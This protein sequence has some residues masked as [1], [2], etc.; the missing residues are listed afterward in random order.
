MHGGDGGLAGVVERK[1]AGGDFRTELPRLPAV[2]HDT[3]RFAAGDVQIDG[4]E[5]QGV[6]PGGRP[7]HVLEEFPGIGR[8]VGLE[9][10]VA[11]L[12]QPG[13]DV[14]GARV[15]AKPVVG[16]D[17]KGRVVPGRI[18]GRAHRRVHARHVILDDRPQALGRVRVVERVRRVVEAPEAVLDAVRG[19]E[20]DREQPFLEAPQFVGEHGFPLPGHVVA[21]RQEGLVRDRAVGEALG[22]LGHAEGAVRA[23]QSLGQFG[24]IA[25][26]G[27][28]GQIG[29]FGIDLDGTAVEGKRF[30]TLQE[31]ARDARHDAAVAA[32]EAQAQ[33]GRPAVGGD[34]ARR[35][36]AGIFE[37]PVAARQREA[38]Y[39]RGALA[40]DQGDGAFHGKD[41]TAVGEADCL[42]LAAPPACALGPFLIADVVA[43]AAFHIRRAEPGEHVRAGKGRRIG[44]GPAYGRN[45]HA[46]A[47]GD[48]EKGGRVIGRR[49]RLQ[50]TGRAGPRQGEPGQVGTRVAHDEVIDA[51][52]PGV[53]SGCEAGPGH[54]ALGGV[55]GVQRR[56]E[57]GRGQPAQMGQPALGHHFP[58][59]ARVQAV[60]AEHDGLAQGFMRSHGIRG[61]SGLGVSD[62]VLVVT[63]A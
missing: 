9:R 34:A 28:D 52:P 16:A 54:G 42:D 35:F 53:G 56:E 30:E 58:A 38:A 6:G 7:V 33:I 10:Q 50:G 4:A 1:Q 26:R 13:V 20:D 62:T 63:G 60:D 25:G 40:G 48:V 15:R 49:G 11:G 61:P 44:H 41:R 46:G 3:L 18:E 12:G 45:R 21:E 29:G 5:S 23:A 51:V 32:G 14:D 37:Q 27:G 22:F 17:E 43:E 55:G 24:G 36:L 31:K 39:G 2:R 19:V 47:H 8:V 59:Q 57:A